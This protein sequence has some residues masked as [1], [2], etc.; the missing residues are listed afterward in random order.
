[1]TWLSVIGA[2]ACGGLIAAGAAAWLC[3][4]DKALREQVF[5]SIPYPRQAV[6]AQGKTLYANK[7]FHK[8]FG[9]A[10][11][12]I[13]DLLLDDLAEDHESRDLIEGLRAAAADGLPGQVEIRVPSEVGSRQEQFGWRLV[14]AYPV[15]ERPGLVYWGVDDI[16]SRRQV[17][18]IVRDEQGRFVDLLE[19]APIGFYSV[20]ETGRFIFANRTLIDWLGYPLGDLE[21][22]TIRLHNVVDG[23]LPEDTPPHDPFGNPGARYGE[24][25]LKTAAG[26]TFSASINQDNVLADDGRHLVTRSV[27]RD[28]TRERAMA[29]ALERSE[30]RFG[31]FFQ[32]APVGI[33]LMDPNGE[34][35]ECNPAFCEMVGRDPSFVRRARLLD[36]VHPEDYQTVESAFSDSTAE[37]RGRRAQAQA[38]IHLGQDRG[39]DCRLYLSRMAGEKGEPLGYIAHFIDTT[40]QKKLEVQFAQSQKMQA[41]GQL[42]GGIAHDFNNLLTAMIGFSDLLLLRHRP[43]D[44]SFADIMQIKQNANRAA[45][46]VRQLLAF[47]RQ[48]TLQPRCLSVTDTLAELAHL[49]RRLIGENI[50]LKISHER[51]LGLVRADQGQLEQVIINLAVN[52]RDAMSDGGTLSVRT[53]NVRLEKDRVLKGETMAAGDYVLIQVADTGCGIQSENIDRIFEPFF[54]TKGV[55]EGT[56]LGLATVYGIIKQSDGFVSVESKLNEG[57]VFSIYLPVSDA[58]DEAL[59]VGAGGLKEKKDL[60]GK[61]T[62]LLVEDEDAVRSF[63][64]RALRNKG[65]KVLE[66][67]SGEAAVTLLND[68]APAVDLVITDVVMPKLDGPG[69]VRHIRETSP[70]IKVIFISGYTE[71]SF[72]KSLDENERIHFLPKPF[73]L[74]QLAGKVK[75]VLEE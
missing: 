17:E 39:T 3:G 46:L 45:N 63:G 4:R 33:A 6:D 35:T 73:S 27:V 12:P 48:Q 26:G 11:R 66:A 58:A 20:D 36:L 41:V 51:D 1:L 7:A 52:A 70:E 67:N 64:A 49:L 38:D 34:I 60:S 19:H 72:R 29:E 42:A 53:A 22:G 50:E 16:T 28:L 23:A 37:R 43:G 62:L 24:V 75:E 30:E 59:S 8:I 47:S 57:T 71:D 44:Q 40:E 55:G 65:Y 69:L 54:S 14:F 13:P 18:E 9:E 2:F 68:D 15:P 56:G 21:D 32:E 25:T 5:A 61:G 10:D 74:K 31:R